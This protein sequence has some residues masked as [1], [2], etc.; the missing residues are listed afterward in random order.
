MNHSMTSVFFALL[1][2]MYSGLQAQIP[3]WDLAKNAGNTQSDKGMSIHRH[4]PSIIYAGGYFSGSITFGQVS[5]PGSGGEDGLMIR[6]TPNGDAAWVNRIAGPGNERVLAITSDGSGNYYATGYFES[7]AGISG[8]FMQS[9]GQKDMFIAKYSQGGVLNWVRNLGSIGDDMGTGVS[10]DAQGNVHLSATY[11]DSLTFITKAGDTVKYASAGGKD[12]IIMKFDEDGKIL[13]H[14]RAGGI[15]DDISADIHIHASGFALTGT[16][17]GK[18]GFKNDSITSNGSTDI[19]L[20]NYSLSTFEP[21]WV[22]TIGGSGA[23]IADDLSS[24]TDSNVYLAGTTTGDFS[25]GQIALTS[26]GGRDGLLAKFSKTGIIQWAQL[27]GA[28]GDDACAGVSVDNAGNVMTTGTF[29]GTTTFGTSSLASRG[30]SDVYVLKMNKNGVIQWAQQ[31]GST[32]NDNVESISNNGAGGAYITGAHGIETILTPFTLNGR[33]GDDFY[34][35]RV[36]D[37]A[38]NDL[39]VISINVPAAPFAPGFRQVSATIANNG[40]NTISSALIELYAG[41]T[42]LASKNWTGPL[43]PGA[44]M[45]VSLDSINFVPATLIELVAVAMTPNGL[46][47]GNSGNNSV[48]RSVGPGLLKGSYTVGGLTPNFKTVADAAHYISHWGILDSVTFH[49][50]PGIYDGQISMNQ[51]PG[52]NASKPVI[53][54]R[55]P[56]FNQAPDI[57]FTSRYAEKNFVM[58]L[59]GTDNMHFD[60]LNFG[61]MS[62]SLGNVIN[63]KNTN[64]SISFNNVHVEIPASAL[65]NGI[66]IDALNATEGLS[67]TNSMFIGGDFGIHSAYDTTL[68]AVNL[69]ISNNQF[70]KFKQ[71]GMHIR[72]TNLATISGNHFEPL[73]SANAGIMLVKGSGNTVIT[74]NVIV[75]L[76][77]GSAI[78]VHEIIGNQQSTTLIANNMAKIGDTNTN[79]SGITLKNTGFAGI[80]HNTI[81]G[82]N[83]SLDAALLNISGGNT[84]TVLNNIFT[85]S[86]KAIIASVAYP[87]AQSMPIVISDYNVMHTD[88]G[89]VGQINDGVNT[90]QFTTLAQWRTGTSKDANSLSKKVAFSSDNLHLNEVDMQ[91]YGDQAVKI[92]INQDIDGEDR[93]NSYMGADE[94][95]PVITITQQPIRTITC[96]T[97]KTMLYVTANATFKG[98]LTYQWTKNG[99]ILPGETND[100]LTIDR[101]SYQ[102]EGFYRCI[103]KSNSGADSV[104]SNQAQL[105]I[106]TRTTILNDLTNQ[107]TVQGGTAIFDIGAEVASIPPSNLARYR[108]FKDSVEYTTNT[109][110]VT[111]VNT[112]RLVLRN[113]QAAD[114]GARYRVI[115]DGGCGSDTSSTV[116]IYMPGVLFAKQPTDTA[117]CLNGKVSVSAEVFPTISGLELAYQWKRATF[118]PVFNTST[119]QGANSPTLIIDSLNPRDTSSNYILEVI[120]V[121]TNARFFS[122]PVKVQLYESTDILRQP[123]SEQVCMNKPYTLSVDARGAEV[124]YQWQRNDTNIIG[125][126]GASYTVPLMNRDLIGRYR[127]I[128]TGI[129]GTKAS[130]VATITALQELVILSQT[131][132]NIVRNL[133]RDLSIN[134][135]AAGVDPLKY[136]W[137]KNGVKIDGATNATYFK[138]DAVIADTGSYWCEVSDRCDT[139]NSKPIQVKLVPVSV[140]DESSV[141]GLTNFGLQQIMPNPA[142][143]QVQ[144]RIMSMMPGEAL[145]EV[146]SILG[147]TMIPSFNVSLESGFTMIPI[148]TEHLIPGTYLCKVTMN[149]MISTQTF[150]IVR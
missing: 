42:K 44:S 25:I 143:D 103:I 131:D 80:L 149:G 75:D 3:G 133:T 68:S 87:I 59:N 67:I 139:I 65:G 22:R 119:I 57:S 81:H 46:Q 121:A 26:Q 91:L 36:L 30:G 86:D 96:D 32:S 6:F 21:I 13:S 113:I 49:V 117:T 142:S 16:Y 38:Q 60:G 45:N 53:F 7:T 137:Y 12:I 23:D 24:D 61:A 120:V 98:Q 94:I 66:S 102:N 8:V 43:A 55:D 31:A 70:K 41:N 39:A 35:A 2:L 37:I 82:L 88:S 104:V 92:I 135:F 10:C 114:T 83:R 14:A 5:I 125:A 123:T 109:N 64:T 76:K 58:E 141:I 106:S 128:V 107:Y 112:P 15:S 77:Q 90:T 73:A 118:I 111:G 85:N 84:I 18:V 134:V 62:T 100:T 99:V 20:A 69:T 29:S 50:R 144:A 17:S 140:E 19:F 40:S 145:I 72:N 79:A 127:V 48:T 89:K 54:K 105:L 101:A 52:S 33:G 78:A 27:I 110:F 63:L 1:F 34:M 115:V 9:N 93:R 95:I 129:C 108:W 130:N 150:S 132:T 122:N 11:S 136:Q 126:T 97:T 56:A 51:I 74:K 71:G 138:S 146:H 148:N 124:T 116:G 47:D 147:S 4:S 28:Q